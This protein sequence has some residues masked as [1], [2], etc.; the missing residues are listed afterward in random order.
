MVKN[1]R[2]VQR[3]E[4]S[5]TRERIVDAAIALLDAD[6]E[7]GLTFRALAGHLSTGAGAL[8]HHIADK[9]DVLD[10]ACDT[11][12]AAV[13]AGA[14]GTTPAARI[15]AIGLGL[16]NAIDAHP[17]AGTEL[18]RVSWKMP[19][20]RILEGVGQAVSALGV[21]AQTVRPATFIL[22][23]YIIGVARQNAA[24]GQIARQRGFVR[25]EFLD[26]LATAWE[27]LD[28]AAFPFMRSIT[29]HV[30]DHDDEADFLA[31]LDLILAGFGVGWTAAHAAAE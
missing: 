20:V 4:T 11:V 18:T 24:N 14:D 27:G 16:F 19:M 12:V 10:A 30:R 9:D 26:G 31:G 13:M 17:W 3:G 1:T 23:N 2:R 7:G 25:S 22:L 29:A 8:Y 15:R 5:L 28:A 21:P 6:G